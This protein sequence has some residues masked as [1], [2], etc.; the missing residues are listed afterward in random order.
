M[1][2]ITDAVTN[3]RRQQRAEEIREQLNAP[4][5][6]QEG[7]AES[8]QEASLETLDR[9]E[10]ASPAPQGIPAVDANLVQS[11]LEEAKES[12]EDNHVLVAY[13]EVEPL[14]KKLLE[15]AEEALSNAKTE[16]VRAAARVDVVAVEKAKAAMLTGLAQ[17]VLGMPQSFIP[18]MQIVDKI[19]EGNKDA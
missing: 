2:R 18:K 16:E 8:A 3:R 9:P 19:E 13:I 5:E 6:G 7:Q 10:N 17:E 1:E 4:V 11:N 14:V 15:G 12:V